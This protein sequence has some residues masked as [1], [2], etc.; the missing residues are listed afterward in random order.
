MIKTDKYK[1]LLTNY[2]RENNR[3]ICIRGI[4]GVGK[5]EVIKATCKELKNSI[6]INYN[7]SIFESSFKE[8]LAGKIKF[9]LLSKGIDCQ[10]ENLSITESIF[11]M[12]NSINI[13]WILSFEDIIE[14]KECDISF[15][16]ELLRITKL[17]S[18]LFIVIEEDIDC[19]NSN[20]Y[21][22]IKECAILKTISV[23]QYT[24]EEITEYICEQYNCVKLEVSE[25]DLKHIYVLSEGTLSITNVIINELEQ[26]GHI[27]KNENTLRITPL[28]SDF[29]INGVEPYILKRFEKLKN[30]YKIIL[31]K[32]SCIGF[33]FNCEDMFGIFS[34]AKIYNI[35]KNI[36][37]ASHLIT[38]FETTQF[39][40]ESREAHR[41]IKE[42]VDKY[43]N[44]AEVIKN[45]AE[46][47]KHSLTE[48]LKITNYAKYMTNLSLSKELYE[49]INDIP[50]ILE[51]YHLMIGN[52]METKLFLEAHMLCLEYERICNNDTMKY[53]NKIQKL[54]CLIGIEDYLNG[55]KLSKDLQQNN[56]N[57]QPYF[58][59]CLALCTY[60]KSEGMTA[61]EILKKLI[62]K[63]KK[64]KDSL[65]YA[66]T[67]R[68]MS[69]IYDF[70]NEWENQL[71]YFSEAIK[72]CKK[73]GLE[74]EYY[75]M[76]RQSGMVYP[77]S[78]AMSM[79]NSA[80]KYFSRENDIKELAKVAHNIATDSMYMMNIELAYEKCNQ[81]I[82]RFKAIGNNNISIP[83]NLMGILICINE[84]KYL[85]SIDYFNNCAILH[86]DKW[87]KCVGYLNASTAYRKLGKIQKSL[88]LINKVKA[89]NNN[90][91]PI[92]T[93]SVKL[94]ELLYYHENKQFEECRKTVA[95]IL[96]YNLE[97]RHKYIIIRVLNSI[98]MEF[99]GLEASNSKI[100]TNY[101]NSTCTE[102]LDRCLS[103]NCYWATTRFWEN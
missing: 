67:L 39:C 100:K 15:I 34:I 68:L 8:I 98:R 24:I 52:K 48:E 79:Y 20:N 81:S 58:Q 92:I 72:T 83:L 102:Y 44:K 87:T 22:K 5:S 73:Y 62:K 85:E 37:I 16:C 40:F 84:G 57:L 26:L 69:S 3:Q 103:I 11:R 53:I 14:A 13:N 65:L 91:M 82:H 32:S 10:I 42:I 89:I 27:V 86:D 21:K 64:S 93:V 9:E 51:C 19:S 63:I 18:N 97:Y 31:A 41:A 35:L 4:S 76:L 77:Y 99:P 66:K 75:S 46:Y 49:V 2:I 29:L 78:I 80:E 94:C 28:P 12:I 23:N 71:H 96:K 45:I 7:F 54:N 95:E 50:N 88:E 74:Y 6:W 61:L 36:Q 90:T 30:E 56:S 55:E 43:I 60:G 33:W 25:S 47:Y 38:E 59:Y 70:Y 1:T 101:I 17:L